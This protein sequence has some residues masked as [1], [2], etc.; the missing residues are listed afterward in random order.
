MKWVTLN[1]RPPE[2]SVPDPSGGRHAKFGSQAGFAVEQVAQHGGT[3]GL[4][5]KDMTD[6]GE[7]RIHR[8]IARDDD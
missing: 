6:A 4:G 2:S 1:E 8:R 5:E 3:D 7:Q